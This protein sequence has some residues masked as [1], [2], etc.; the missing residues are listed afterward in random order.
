MNN[1]EER[2]I[3]DEVI[4]SQLITEVSRVSHSSPC[5]CQ[6]TQ[7]RE[8]PWV[9]VKLRRSTWTKFLKIVH[10]RDTKSLMST[11]IQ[12]KRIQCQ[13]SS[14]L[15]K[16][17]HIIISILKT[18]SSYRRGRA[19]FTKSNFKRW[20]ETIDRTWTITHGSR[21]IPCLK[22]SWSQDKIHLIARSI[23]CRTSRHQTKATNT[24]ELTLR[25][26]T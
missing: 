16:K 5:K 19:W 24:L 13:G 15:N 7:E 14:T 3:R 18:W 17:P 23:H 12:M 1:Q 22:D 9:Q 6:D 20:K 4:T 25:P 26:S 10:S 11:K 8:H 21:V 2:D